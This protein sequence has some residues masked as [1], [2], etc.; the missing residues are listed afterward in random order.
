MAWTSSTPARPHLSDSPSTVKYQ[1]LLATKS[2]VPTC[3]LARSVPPTH[4][5][6]FLAFANLLVAAG[7]PFDPLEFASDPDTLAEL[8]VKEIKNGRLAMF[9][10][11]G[12]FVQAIVTGKVLIVDF[13]TQS[14]LHAVIA[15]TS[16][17]VF[18]SSSC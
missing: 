4:Y 17:V 2:R 6:L 5:T 13:W 12:F 1:T 3:S 15:Y 10:M 9:S 7:G 8:K 16:T 14:M 11:L 18:G